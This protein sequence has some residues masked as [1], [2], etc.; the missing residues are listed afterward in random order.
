MEVNNSFPANYPC[1]QAVHY[2]GNRFVVV[3]TRNYFKTFKVPVVN[4]QR[5]CLFA[6]YIMYTSLLLRILYALNIYGNLKITGD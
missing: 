6:Y 2:K 4:L 5:I 3:L 1:Y